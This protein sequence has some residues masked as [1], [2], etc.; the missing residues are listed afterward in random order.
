MD[1]SYVVSTRDRIIQAT[2]ELIK[3]DG[4]QNVTVRK[5]ANNANVNIASINYHFGS[6][7]A[8]INEALK[9]VTDELMNCFNIL[10]AKD[11]SAELRL[12]KFL[13]DYSDVITKYPDIIKSFISLLMNNCDVPVPY[14]D[15]LKETGLNLLVEAI[16]EIHP[17][18]EDSL[19]SMR[20]IQ[21]M[22][23]TAYPVL[24]GSHLQV[25]ASFDFNS[26]EQRYIYLEMLLKSIVK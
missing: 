7:D 17:D 26:Q 16:K 12:R 6:K 24:L 13:Q 10:E 4:F 5:I 23:C 15:F 8:V 9:L 19:I 20:T 18:E 11:L 25:S 22:G 14:G 2:L 1:N 21:L 3:K